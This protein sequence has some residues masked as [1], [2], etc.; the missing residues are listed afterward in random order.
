MDY[1]SLTYQ[2][3]MDYNRFV[4]QQEELIKDKPSTLETLEQRIMVLE[5][6]VKRLK[7]LSIC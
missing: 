2:D 1:E 3:M 5:N 6:E 4:S 7:L